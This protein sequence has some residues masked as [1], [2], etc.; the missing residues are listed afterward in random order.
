MPVQQFFAEEAADDDYKSETEEEDVPDEDFDVSEQVT[1]RGGRCVC[2]C[3]WGGKGAGG[4]W[5]G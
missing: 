2:V 5:V 1:W 4:A 3:V